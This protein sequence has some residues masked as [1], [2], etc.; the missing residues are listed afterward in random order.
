[1]TGRWAR[2]SATSAT[3]A[4][5]SRATTISSTGKE[6][7]IDVSKV[8]VSMNGIELQDREFFAAIRE[9]R[10][11]NASGG[12]GAALLQG[13]ARSRPAARG[14]GPMKTQVAIIGCGPGGAAARPSAARR[15]SMPSSSSARRSEY[16]MPRIR[17]GVLERTTTDL[18]HRLGVDARLNAE[19]L[20]PRRLRACRW[21]AADPHRL[22]RADRQAA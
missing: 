10:E 4:H 6:E 19:G 22:R 13:A 18:L 17:A 7:K 16:V 2:S 5:R 20:P 3:T 9:G 11:P 1:M 12:A 15:A 21:R 14:H 8:D